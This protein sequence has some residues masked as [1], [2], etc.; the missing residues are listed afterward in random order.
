MKRVAPKRAAK[1]A[2]KKARKTSKIATR[3]Q[4]D[5]AMKRVAPKR[6]AKK[7]TKKATKKAVKKSTTPR[8]QSREATREDIDAFVQ[9]HF[10][11][12]IRTAVQQEVS[13]AQLGQLHIPSIPSVRAKNTLKYVRIVATGDTRRTWEE[14]TIALRSLPPGYWQFQAV[15]GPNDEYH[16]EL[17]P[18]AKSLQSYVRS[19]LRADTKSGISDVQQNA[20]Q[21][22]AENE[23]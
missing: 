19:S 2:T 5:A 12:E 10:K 17:S 4:I 20:K 22:L 1:K 15:F 14:A 11:K 23:I 21:F 16:G 18:R 9:K 8:F 7:A 3:K 13:S 6:A